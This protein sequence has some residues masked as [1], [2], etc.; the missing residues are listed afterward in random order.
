[1]VTTILIH[2]T[3]GPVDVLVNGLIGPPFYHVPESVKTA[4]TVV[5]SVRQLVS[6]NGAYGSII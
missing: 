1:M 6:K 3:L 2:K 5:E 4:T